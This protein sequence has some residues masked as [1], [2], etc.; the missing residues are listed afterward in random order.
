MMHMLR[1]AW[2]AAKPKTVANCFKKTLWNCGDH[3]K[4][5]T[6]ADM[7]NDEEWLV[8]A[9]GSSITSKSLYSVMIVTSPPVCKKMWEAICNR[10]KMGLWG[11]DQKKPVPAFGEAVEAYEVVR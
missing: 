4:T 1:A 2:N 6:D 8:G 9:S 10:N 3:I 5:E 7:T 11:E